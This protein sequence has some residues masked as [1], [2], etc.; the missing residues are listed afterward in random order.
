M[1]V[2]PFPV[3]QLLAA[4]SMR[5]PQTLTD[6]AAEDGDGQAYLEARGMDF[7][8]D[9]RKVAWHGTATDSIGSA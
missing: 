7:L 4:A 9:L 6:A 8:Q 1:Q 2:G 5:Q 3:L